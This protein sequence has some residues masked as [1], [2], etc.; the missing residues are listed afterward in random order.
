VS[1]GGEVCFYSFA[2]THLLADINGYFPSGTAFSAVSPTL[3]FDTR[4]ASADG[5]R[6]VDKRKVGSGYE[7]A[8]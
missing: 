5:L 7:L 4:P 2:P 6:V 8:V 1:P 3:I